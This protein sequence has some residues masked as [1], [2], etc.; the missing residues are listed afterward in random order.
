[1]LSSV[2][3]TFGIFSMFFSVFCDTFS[4]LQLFVKIYRYLQLF[5]FICMLLLREDLF[6]GDFYV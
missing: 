5:I 2:L 3:F 1:M 6:K 4:F